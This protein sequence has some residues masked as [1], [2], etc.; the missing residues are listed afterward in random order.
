[1]ILD[2]GRSSHSVKILLLW[3]VRLK[4]LTRAL[5]GS[6]GLYGCEKMLHVECKVV[7]A[8]VVCNGGSR[9]KVDAFLA[10]V[11]R[12]MR[13]DLLE[14]VENVPAAEICGCCPIFSS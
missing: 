3:K 12:N 4:I 7:D 1:M 9:A 10:G 14:K 13:P 8:V 2:L 5:G 6:R 11:R